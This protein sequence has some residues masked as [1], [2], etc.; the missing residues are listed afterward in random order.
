[1]SKLL[2]VIA[3]LLYGTV[4]FSQEND[5]LF[6]V[7]RN[8]AWLIQHKIK[9]GETLFLISRRFHVPPAILAGANRLPFTQNFATID[10]VYIPVSAYTP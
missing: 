2:L 5:S 10:S 9:K 6:A 1:M 7:E 4:G 8:N 3:F